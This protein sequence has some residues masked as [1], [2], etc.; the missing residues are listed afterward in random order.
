[1]AKQYLPTKPKDG[2][3]TEPS[4]EKII[5]LSKDELQTVEGFVIKNMHGSISFLTPIDLV[6]VDLENEI[7]ITSEGAEVYPEQPSQ[8]RQKHLKG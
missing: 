2:Y 7:L 6:G 3:V 1:M 5:E 4:Y 8:L